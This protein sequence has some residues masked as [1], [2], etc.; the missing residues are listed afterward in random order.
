MTDHTREMVSQI[1]DEYYA[2]TAAGIYVTSGTRTAA[3]QA[4]AMYYKLA[5]GDLLNEYNNRH[6]ANEISQA[7]ING[8]AAHKAE[9]GIISD[10]TTVISNQMSNGVYISR[11]LRGG[12][13]DVRNRDMSRE[14]KAAFLESVR[15]VNNVT[16]LNEG[17]PPHY[18][19]QIN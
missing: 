2:R 7:Y 5:H 19:L 12:A 13:V 10:M 16:V 8:V 11:H 17:I 6:A 18:H 15:A 1:A 4:G 14:Q 3:Q 9:A